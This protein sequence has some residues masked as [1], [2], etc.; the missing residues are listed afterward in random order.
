MI[1]RS[2]LNNVPCVSFFLVTLPFLLSVNLSCEGILHPQCNILGQARSHFPSQAS[3]VS[4]YC[5]FYIRLA[6]GIFHR[7]MV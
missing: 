7:Y 1:D 3:Y 5:L 6:P 2:P 4:Y